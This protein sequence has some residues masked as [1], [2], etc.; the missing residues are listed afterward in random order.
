[1]AYI[2][3]NHISKEISIF[4]SNSFRK[5]VFCPRSTEI[6]S[7]FGL[8][9]ERWNDGVGTDGVDID[10]H[11]LA[12]SSPWHGKFVDFIVDFD[13]HAGAAIFLELVSHCAHSRK[14]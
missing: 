9:F 2:E 12:T 4:F 10:C 14:L 13:R 8:V 3:F 5:S 1:M 6:S 11:H 7:S